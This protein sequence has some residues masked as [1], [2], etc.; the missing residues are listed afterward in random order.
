MPS[1][2]KSQRVLGFDGA[3][4][5]CL[6]QAARRGGANRSDRQNQRQTETAQDDKRDKKD[7]TASRSAKNKAEVDRLIDWCRTPDS[8]VWDPGRDVGATNAGS[9]ARWATVA[10]GMRNILAGW[11]LSVSREEKEEEEK[12]EDKKMSWF[13]GR[14]CNHGRPRALFVQGA[15]CSMANAVIYR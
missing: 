4:K 5:Q 9:Y 12:A 13:S 6:K 3:R 14:R 15:V 7:K 1:S 8:A 11:C 2:D 10:A